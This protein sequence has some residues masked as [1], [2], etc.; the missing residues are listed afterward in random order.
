M[1]YIKHVNE[2]NRKWRE[3]SSSIKIVASRERVFGLTSE[4]ETS[5]FD[6]ESSAFSVLLYDKCFAS[7]ISR[8]GCHHNFRDDSLT[9][10]AAAKIN[11]HP[12]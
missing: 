8:V 6:T 1:K 7:L 5:F 3:A 11:Y 4:E 9:I 12:H 2:N 10:Q